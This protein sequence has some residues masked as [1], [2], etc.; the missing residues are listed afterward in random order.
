[1]IR[2]D[3]N[4]LLNKI[5]VAFSSGKSEGLNAREEDALLRNAA[6]DKLK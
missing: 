1:M 2:K 5:K 4:D 3:L 6:G